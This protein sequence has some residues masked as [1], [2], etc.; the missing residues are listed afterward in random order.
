ML[1]AESNPN[2]CV[3]DDI[4]AVVEFE[5]EETGQRILH[6]CLVLRGVVEGW[7]VMRFW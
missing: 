2:N 6:N 5:T 7:P 3:C 1:V 4:K